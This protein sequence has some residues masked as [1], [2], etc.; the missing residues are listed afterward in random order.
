MRIVIFHTDAE[1][2]RKIVRDHG[3]G[4]SVINATSNNISVKYNVS[5]KWSYTYLSISL[6][7]FFVYYLHQGSTTHAL[8]ATL[9]PIP[10]ITMCCGWPV[11]VCFEI[12]LIILTGLTSDVS[13]INYGGYLVNLGVFFSCP[14]KIVVGSFV[15]HWLRRLGTPDLHVVYIKLNFIFL[16]QSKMSED[17]KNFKG[18]TDLP[19]YDQSFDSRNAENWD[20]GKFVYVQKQSLC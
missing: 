2:I 17:G 15:V 8:H 6:N 10:P 9:H 4:V 18:C 20:E 5:V 1:D 14:F 12:V 19:K 16:E 13:L 3:W 7:V 11:P